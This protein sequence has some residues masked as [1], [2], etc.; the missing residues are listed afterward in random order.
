MRLGFCFIVGFFS[1]LQGVN[2]VFS[3]HFCK[4]LPGFEIR[5]IKV[6]VAGTQAQLIREYR[7]RQGGEFMTK[8]CYLIALLGLLLSTA[9][10]TAQQAPQI[11]IDYASF[12]YDEQES[13]VELYMA[14]EAGS[15]AYEEG[16]SLYTSSIPLELSLLSSS[17]T[18]LDA[19]A[20]RVVWE[21]QMDLQFA[22]MDP[23]AIT[24]GQVFLRQVR[25]TVVPGEYELQ[26]AMPLSDQDP[27]QASRDVIIPD[28]SQQESCALSDITLASRIAPSEDREDPFFKNKLHIRPNASQLYG[29]G[30]ANL[31]YY[32]EA[33]NT[34]CAASGTG[35]YNM[36]IYVS[37]GGKPVPIK[38]LE[39]RSKR[40]VRPTDVLVGQFDLSALASGI[41]L[42][43]M[44]ILD[45]TRE[46]KVEQTRKFRVFNSV[47]DSARPQPAIFYMNVDQVEQESIQIR[48]AED[49]TAYK[50]HTLIHRGDQSIR[51]RHAEDIAAFVFIRER[52][53]L[54]GSRRRLLREVKYP[55]SARNAGIEGQVVVQFTV[56]EEGNA[57]NAVIL[58]GIGGGCDEEAI[59]VITEHARF[60]PG[61]SG[62]IAVPV[63]MSMPIR[64]KPR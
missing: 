23:S 27:V 59:R 51:I 64:C 56:D 57:R 50:S 1:L 47:A 10:S 39:K 7:L 48:H 42:L 4:R 60:K 41:Y 46:S 20:E 25:L 62:E 43:R 49:I 14:I 53:E 55:E 26:I 16:D 36:L 22:V 19:S 2:A 34:A 40:A 5:L 33:Y 58:E 44:E 9:S 54:I 12:A 31:F 63:T 29:E 38:G 21:R 45:N 24:E 35:E 28:Y 61:I 13:L 8:K 32:A 52:P 6:W 17:D 18:D 30:A 3:V 37:K 15:L 11:D